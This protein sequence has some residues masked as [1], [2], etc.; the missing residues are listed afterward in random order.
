MELNI[1]GRPFQVP[2]EWREE[3]LLWVLREAAGL[4]G[5]KFGC[6]VGLCGACTVWVDAKPGRACVLSLESVQGA[7]I[8]TI[9]GLQHDGAPHPV[10][11]AWEALNVPQ[12]GYCQA[13]QIM[14][15][16]AL[17]HQEPNPSDARIEE[18]MS[19]QLCR[20]GTYARIRPAVRLATRIALQQPT[21]PA[22]ELPAVLQDAT[23][24]R[25]TQADSAGSR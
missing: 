19:E 5:T 9:E 1:N 12:C 22:S 24:Q 11:Q 21:R 4:V 16:A 25:T 10:Q 18:V 20:C 23:Q 8:T 3:S 17:L 2:P 13:G 6:G 14:R 7:R 15:A